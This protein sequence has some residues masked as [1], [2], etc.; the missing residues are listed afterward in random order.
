MCSS[1][2][3]QYVVDGQHLLNEISKVNAFLCMCVN[4]NKA[5]KIIH[6]YLW[7][8]VEFSVNYKPRKYRAWC[9]HNSPNA[10]THST[11]STHTNGTQKRPKFNL[12]RA[13]YT[14]TGSWCAG[15]QINCIMDDRDTDFIR[16]I[17]MAFIKSRFHPDKRFD[18]RASKVRNAYKSCPR[19]RAHN[20]SICISAPNGFGGLSDWTDG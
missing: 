4:R 13:N 9:S 5:E 12:I 1:I 3:S 20:V 11:H 19:A 8:R 2:S 6:F 15:Y 17:P 7:L 14:H 10:H 16:I 18:F